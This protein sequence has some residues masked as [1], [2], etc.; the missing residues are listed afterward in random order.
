MEGSVS[1][2]LCGSSA[3]RNSVMH[4]D[5]RSCG[6]G[7]EEHCLMSWFISAWKYV[8]GLPGICIFRNATLTIR[9]RFY[10]K[11]FKPVIK[12]TTDGIFMSQHCIWGKNI[13]VVKSVFIFETAVLSWKKRE[14]CI[15]FVGHICWFPCF[16][17][18]LYKFGT[19]WNAKRHWPETGCRSVGEDWNLGQQKRFL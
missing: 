3:V 6:W 5:T 4:W 18:I 13:C 12:S 14:V 9:I 2:S 1:V 11:L 17:Q 7:K 16:S 8:L 19:Q 15:V 10:S